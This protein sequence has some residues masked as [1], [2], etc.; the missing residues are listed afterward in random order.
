MS[1][2]LAGS[3]TVQDVQMRAVA[4]IGWASERAIA[5]RRLKSRSDFGRQTGQIQTQ[6]SPR[7]RHWYREL[8]A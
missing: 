5:P 7:G 3:A 8:V 1:A 2:N 6:M 4:E